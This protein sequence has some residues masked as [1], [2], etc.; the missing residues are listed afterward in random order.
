VCMECIMSF[1]S[2]RS[3]GAHCSCQP[4]N[5]PVMCKWIAYPCRD[6]QAQQGTPNLVQHHGMDSPQ[7]QSLVRSVCAD[8]VPQK[9]HC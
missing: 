2:G 7:S 8:V 9:C 5:Q 6:D 3:V 4:S 1:R